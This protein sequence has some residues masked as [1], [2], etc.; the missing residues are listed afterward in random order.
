MRCLARSILPVACALL[1]SCAGYRAYEQGRDAMVEGDSER[2]LAK[3]EEAV[4]A[5]PNNYVYRDQYERQKT[6]VIGKLLSNGDLLRS[7]GD[8]AKAQVNYQKVLKLD[9]DDE[10]AKKSIAL[11]Q[12]AAQS[13]A[14][15][16][17]AKIDVDADELD[18]ADAKLREVLKRDPDNPGARD[19]LNQ[20]NE[21]RAE[22]KGPRPELKGPFAKPITHVMRVGAIGSST[23]D[24]RTR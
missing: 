21:K 5:S 7:S 17:S 10:H 16:A 14:D 20:I 19:L 2:S 22:M 13:L 23:V 6:V 1:V 11:V 24:S 3:L 8:L 12:M 18:K 15:V 4:K 9:P